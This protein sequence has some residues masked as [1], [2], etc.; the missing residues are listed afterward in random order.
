MDINNKIALVTGSNRGIG[1]ALVR[2][3]LDA[4]ATEVWAGARDIESLGQTIALDPSRVKPVQ[5]D[6]TDEASV[7]AARSLISHLDILINNAG[8]AGQGSTL[9]GDIDDFRDMFETNVFGTLSTTRAFTPQLVAS[10]GAVLNVM[11]LLSLA[12]R[13]GLAGYSASKAALRSIHL[14]LRADLGAQGVEVHGL[15][16]ALVDTRLT[17][18]LNEGKAT[19]DEVAGAAITGLMNDTPDIYPDTVSAQGADTW[20]TNPKALEDFMILL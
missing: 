15:L 10:K 11:S 20:E 18:K 5:I 1:A 14:A 8:I 7:A 9:D 16:P 17:E 19:T 4:G 12:P 2:H 3:L 6:I 13:T